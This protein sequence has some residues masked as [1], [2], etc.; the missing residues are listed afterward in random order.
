[1]TLHSTIARQS[2]AHVPG[3]FNR[4][5]SATGL[6]SRAGVIIRAKHDANERNAVGGVA[7]S[8]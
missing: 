4:S 6:P 2:I 8:D 5:I 7:M 1:V 3:P